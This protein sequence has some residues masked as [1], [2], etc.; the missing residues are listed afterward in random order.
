MNLWK[1]FALYR[2]A[3]SGRSKRPLPDDCELDSGYRL[4]VCWSEAEKHGNGRK[5]GVMVDIV[6]SR[7][8][9]FNLECL[10]I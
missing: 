6:L 4:R 7:R 9:I 10:C 5:D 1:L 2:L 3:K 8:S